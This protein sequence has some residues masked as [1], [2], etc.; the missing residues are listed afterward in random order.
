MPSDDELRVED[1]DTLVAAFHRVYLESLPQGQLG[2]AWQRA[3]PRVAQLTVDDALEMIA[4]SRKVDP[5]VKVHLVASTVRRKPGLVNDHAV[6]LAALV[7]AGNFY[8][9]DANID[10]V[11]AL[12]R[13]A[14][15][16]AEDD[17]PPDEPAERG[18]PDVPIESTDG[19]SEATTEDA[20]GHPGEEGAS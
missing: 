9:A 18:S 11:D 6:G 15:E 5:L 10:V 7:K 4:A 1:Q 8:V 14:Q 12:R 16:F 2:P 13:L 19:R 20:T 3:D 17:A